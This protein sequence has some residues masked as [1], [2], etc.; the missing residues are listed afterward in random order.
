MLKA[1]TV[2]NADLCSKLDIE[3]L[4][5]LLALGAEVYVD[6]EDDDEEDN[7]E[8]EVHIKD[9]VAR[10]N[11]A[12]IALLVPDIGYDGLA[13]EPVVEYAEGKVVITLDLD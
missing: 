6:A 9:S 1:L 8:L 4:K 5:K 11:L 12:K 13:C 3:D 10:L 2:R 7:R